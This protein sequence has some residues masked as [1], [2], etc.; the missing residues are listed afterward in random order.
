M[1]WRFLE[2]LRIEPLCDLTVPLLDIYPKSILLRL[3]ILVSYS[4]GISGVQ[5]AGEVLLTFAG[6]QAWPRVLVA[7]SAGAC[8]CLWSQQ[9]SKFKTNSMCLPQVGW[10]WP[11]S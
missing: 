5:G 2:K 9:A 10:L 1:I 7:G 11:H 6:P 4:S 8:R 3:G